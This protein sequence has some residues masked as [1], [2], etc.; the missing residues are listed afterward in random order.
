[1]KYTCIIAAF[2]SLLMSNS[3]FADVRMRLMFDGALWAP[4]ANPEFAC[5]DDAKQQWFDCGLAQTGEPGEYRRRNNLAPGSYV[6]LIGVDA[7][8]NNLKNMPGDWRADYRFKI[9]PDS[10]E[11]IVDVPITKLIHLVKPQSNDGPMEG[12]LGD[13][14]RN[15]PRFIPAGDPWTKELTIPFE[16][17]SVIKG[18]TYKIS[19]V[20]RHCETYGDLG[21]FR[22]FETNAPSLAVTLPPNADD[23]YYAIFISAFKDG[24]FIGDFLT[25]DA[26]MQSWSYG[27]KVAPVSTPASYYI[28][29]ACI[30]LLLVLLWFALGY[31]GL[32]IWSRLLIQFLLILGVV[33]GQQKIPN[34]NSL[35]PYK[36]FDVP[37]VFP[38]AAALPEAKVEQAQAK[39]VYAYSWGK[40]VPKPRWWKAVVPQRTINNYGELQ[41]W[42]QSQDSGTK[43]RREFFKAIYEAIERHPEDEH[44]AVTG[45]D[46]LFYLADDQKSLLQVGRIAIEHHL[47]YVQRTDNCAGCAAG[48]TI[49][50]IANSYARILAQAKGPTKAIAMLESVLAA[51]EKDMSVYAAADSYITLVDFLYRVKRMKNAR[52]R[53]DHALTAF[54]GTNRIEQLK[55]LDRLIPR[56]SKTKS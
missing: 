55:E 37:P 22:R 1:M 38:V 30:A 51:R 10:D 4:K 21:V 16:W 45:M 35:P 43:A 25:Y 31:L 3:S 13:N 32:G 17:E 9:A 52:E 14:C 47:N 2:L 41:L 34:A 18:A 39:A 40:E 28:A 44:L 48:D 49:A 11:Q 53:L 33:L 36:Y 6:I 50:Q 26:G 12:A 23:E 29:A 56:F 46:Y 20:R 8:R 15:K 19:V 24:R 5:L 7:N 42:W 54:S 27:F